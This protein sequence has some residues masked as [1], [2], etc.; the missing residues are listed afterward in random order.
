[1]EELLDSQTTA[2]CRTIFDYLE[3]RRDRITAKHFG[4]KQLIILRSCNELL[5][6]LSRAEDTKFCGRVFIFL[7]QSFPLHDKSSVNL[8]GEFH[9]ENI[10]TYDEIPVDGMDID[11]NH[12]NAGLAV[13][14]SADTLSSTKP[15]EGSKSPSAKKSEALSTDKLYPIF[16][17]LQQSLSQPKTLFDKDV[18]AQFRD[19]VD[20]TKTMFTSVQEQSHA[21]QTRTIEEAKRSPKRKRSDEDDDLAD[22]F[23][24]KYLTSRDLFELEVSV[25]HMLRLCLILIRLSAQRSLLPKAHIGT[26][27]HYCRFLVVTRS[28]KQS[29]SVGGTS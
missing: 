18:F 8:R 17:S 7:F 9:T 14:S 6:R 13:V 1:M 10:T 11:G 24:P 28:Y 3:S 15:S 12:G 29:Q 21:R 22:A 2:S 4:Q 27:P 25:I 23:N 19:A 5:R 16:W 26:N 20:A